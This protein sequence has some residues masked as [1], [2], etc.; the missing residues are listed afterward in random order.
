LLCFFSFP[1]VPCFAF[2]CSRSPSTCN[3]FF[4]PPSGP[5]SFPSDTNQYSD[6]SPRCNNFFHTT[7][8]YLSTYY[9]LPELTPIRYPSSYR[10]ATQNRSQTALLTRSDSPGPFRRKPLRQSI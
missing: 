1:V 2:H 3:N 7:L 6:P 5:L 9:S 8:D 4:Q 10:A